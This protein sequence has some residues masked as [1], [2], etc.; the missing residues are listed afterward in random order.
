MTPSFLIRPVLAI[1]LTAGLAACGAVDSDPHRFETMAERVA[2]VPLDG[3]TPVQSAEAPSRPVRTA[4]SNGL[5]PALRVEVMDPHALWDARDGMV[6]QASARVA[7][8][9]AP[10][11]V[12]AVTREAS[13]RI[14]TALSRPASEAEPRLRPA[15]ATAARSGQGL[16]Q[17][18]AYSSHEGARA[19]WNRL[20]SGG[21]AWALD[22][23]S[24]TFETV[25]IDGRELV[26][27]KVRAPGAGAA[28]LCAAA[29]IDDPWCRRS[30]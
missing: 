16:V 23:L 3:S 20:K 15:I 8:A 22:G 27:L 4:A 6:Q 21:A 7:E 10:V 5:R 25:Q 1:L 2:A 18:G 30:A 14:E 26:R 19:A 13:N 17:L 12:R 24:P 29:G 28:A 9:A 11:V